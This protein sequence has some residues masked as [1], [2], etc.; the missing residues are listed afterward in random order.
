MYFLL[1]AHHRHITYIMNICEFSVY[2]GR[3]NKYYNL[4]PHMLL[5]LATAQ[6]KQDFISTTEPVDSLYTLLLLDANV[7]DVT[8][9]SRLKPYVQWL[10]V[11]VPRD[12]R[13]II[14]PDFGQLEVWNKTFQMIPRSGEPEN[15][16]SLARQGHPYVFLAY[17][18]R[19][20]VNTDAATNL[21]DGYL[22]SE[23]RFVF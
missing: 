22:S 7:D 6:S 19:S 18:Q 12:H 10:T 13:S 20:M 9:G 2:S 23:L 8:K 16:R 4:K 11:N 14:T 21:M 3:S 15:M 1:I 5:K 17:R